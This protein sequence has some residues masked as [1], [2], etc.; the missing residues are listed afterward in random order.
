VQQADRE[1][2]D[3]FGPEVVEDRRQPAQVERPSLAAVLVQPAGH[4]PPQAPRYERRRLR[5]VEVEVVRPIAAGDLQHVAEALGR[6]QAGEDALAFR[7]RV[8]HERR[9]VRE[10]N[11]VGERDAAPREHVQH[12][13][14]EIRRRRVGLRRDD[15]LGTRGGIGEEVDEIGERAADV[16]CRPDRG[17]GVHRAAR[18][19]GRVSTGA[20][21]RRSR[22]ISRPSST[23][24]AMRP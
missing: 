24:C 18:S 10:V 9:P 17:S 16:G 22:S 7:Q 8:D 21:G 13:P 19:S 12:A 23:T 2:F 3:A 6:D 15:L 4:L 5:V 14:L 11:D 1:R 20:T